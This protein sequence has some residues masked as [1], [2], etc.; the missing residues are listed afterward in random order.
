MIGVALA[1]ALSQDP[2]AAF[3]ADQQ[4]AQDR[5][6]HD[7]V[8]P[9]NWECADPLIS[10]NFGQSVDSRDLALRIADECARPYR[11]R[12]VS[13]PASRLFKQQEKTVYSYQLQTFQSEVEI[14]IQQA[15]RRAAIH[16]N[17]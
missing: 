16:L 14:E 13:D 8:E 7:A 12:A 4:A 6:A 5:Y 2:M 17:R 10:R 9:A 1:L 11:A 3:R 15:R